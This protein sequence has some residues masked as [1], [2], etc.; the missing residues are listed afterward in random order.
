VSGNKPLGYALMLGAMAGLVIVA[1]GI[2]YT[3]YSCTLLRLA[4]LLVYAAIAGVVAWLG[5]ALAHTVLPR[6]DV[7]FE[8]LVE[9]LRR[10]V[11]EVRGEA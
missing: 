9:K 7:S 3:D 1:Y 4:G 11:E 2:F 5:Y 6:E 10:E 8:D